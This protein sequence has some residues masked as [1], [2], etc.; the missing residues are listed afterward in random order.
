MSTERINPCEDCELRNQSACCNAPIIH[1]DICSD[2][3]EHCDV[4]CEDCEEKLF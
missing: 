3:K 4:A 1:S 2:C